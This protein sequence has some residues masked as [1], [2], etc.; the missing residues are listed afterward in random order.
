MILVFRDSIQFLDPQ[1]LALTVVSAEKQLTMPPKKKSKNI[2]T[3]ADQ[4]D[5]HIA[6]DNGNSLTTEPSQI[7]NQERRAKLEALEK[8]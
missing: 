4:E 3:E 1:T 5:H 8:A 6:E 2:P 7:S